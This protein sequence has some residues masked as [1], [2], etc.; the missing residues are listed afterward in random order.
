MHKQLQ[1]D[2]N[3]LDQKIHE[4]NDWIAANP[5]DPQWF[6]KVTQRHSL[7]VDIQIK[8]DQ[9]SGNWFKAQPV[10]EIIRIPM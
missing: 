3:R 9:L 1:K 6:S 2:I 8:R 4:L 5:N 7:Q 10:V